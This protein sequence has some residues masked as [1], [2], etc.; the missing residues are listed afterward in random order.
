MYI[1]LI[2]ALALVACVLGYSFPVAGGDSLCF[3]EKYDAPHRVD[4]SFS[5]TR[6]G[7]LL[8]SMAIKGPDR[9]TVYSAS[10]KSDGRFSFSADAGEYS[11]CFDNSGSHQ[12]RTLIFHVEGV[13]VAKEAA[14]AAADKPEEGSIEQEMGQIGE[15]LDSIADQQ[16]EMRE[17]DQRHRN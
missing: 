11:F 5:V 7:D 14:E 15:V 16:R 1:R 9:S 4:G 3:Y 6:G 10:N 17:R 12:A 8:V 13:D 2:A